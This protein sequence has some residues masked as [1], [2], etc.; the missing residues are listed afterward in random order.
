MQIIK[1]DIAISKLV[2]NRDGE[3]SLVGSID[4]N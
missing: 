1:L 3:R 2:A 4:N